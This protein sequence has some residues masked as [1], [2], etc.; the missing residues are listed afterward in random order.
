MTRKAIKTCE[1]CTVAKARQKN[2]KRHYKNVKIVKFRT[3]EDENMEINE[4]V[5]VDLSKIGTPSDKIASDP[6]LKKPNWLL[7]HDRATGRT[8]SMFLETKAD[9]VEPLC[10]LFCKWKQEGKPVK[11]VR[12][13][14]AGE[15]LKLEQRL[16]SSDWKLGD[17][18]LEYTSRNTP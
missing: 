2:L 15:N 8:H 12:M 7:I 1:A 14:N 6:N 10:A 17:I 5:S 16:R 18:K 4:M 9:M 3:K 13:D 11:R